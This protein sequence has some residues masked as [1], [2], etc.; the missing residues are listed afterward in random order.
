VF[1][2]DETFYLLSMPKKLVA[3]RVVPEADF[4]QFDFDAEAVKE[5][6]EYLYF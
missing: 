6:N 4:A 3:R 2:E 5:D 1:N